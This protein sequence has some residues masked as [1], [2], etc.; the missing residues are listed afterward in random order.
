[1]KKNVFKLTE[2]GLLQPVGYFTLKSREEIL[3]IYKSDRYFKSDFVTIHP[4]LAQKIKES[5]LNTS[6]LRRVEILRK[7]GYYV[8]L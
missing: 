7:N 8:S 5:D 4:S 6:I 1:M 3:T 2:S